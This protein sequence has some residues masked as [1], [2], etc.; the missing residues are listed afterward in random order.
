MKKLFLAFIAICNLQIVNAAPRGSGTRTTGTLGLYKPIQFEN[1][2]WLTDSDTSINKDLDIID[3]SMTAI[4]NGTLSSMTSNYILNTSTQ[5][6]YSQAR[7]N[8]LVVVDSVT[9]PTGF[10][11][12]VEDISPGSTHYV[13][14]RDS[15][16]AG[17]TA[18][19][20]YVRIGTVSASAVSEDTLFSVS[21]GPFV[22]RRDGRLGLGTTN[23]NVSG[24]G[25]TGLT[26]TLAGQP[27]SD[28]HGSLEMMNNN[29][30]APTSDIGQISYHAGP[31][32]NN[33]K[34][35]VRRDGSN[36]SSRW[37]WFGRSAQSTVEIQMML[38]KLGRLRL[39]HDVDDSSPTEAT[40][41][42][43]VSSGAI[44]RSSITVNGTSTLGDDSTDNLVISASSI[45]LQ[46]QTTF[47]V[48]SSLYINGQV[49]LSTPTKGPDC[50]SGFRRSGSSE[51][52]DDD[53]D[54]ANLLSSSPTSVH[55]DF[56][57]LDIP[58]LNTTKARVLKFKVLIVVTP[59]GG[60]TAGNIIFHVR[61]PGGSASPGASNAA[62]QRDTIPLA[63][64]ETVIYCT[65]E[66]AL[67]LLSKDMDY[68]CSIAD[69]AE[70]SQSCLLYFVGYRE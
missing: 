18:F 25:D 14:T 35:L 52:D 21:T 38:D 70:T 17:A 40:H 33:A 55:S 56:V 61:T 10:L 51:C 66:I 58:Q 53:G 41:Q 67:N 64:T 7:L 23:L 32:T 9:L 4:I 22:I 45:T 69:D 1:Q 59:D 11:L 46:N 29:P 19:P 13:Q 44:I 42:L 30:S 36:T 63:T 31:T 68:S 47:Y 50:I 15:L 24:Y 65:G 2:G 8:K 54:Y 49:E 57:T 62:C 3:S 20:A 27:G 6:G 12:P 37:Y 34:L 5:A 60:A 26:L 28:R 16:Q 39:G 48:N 43:D